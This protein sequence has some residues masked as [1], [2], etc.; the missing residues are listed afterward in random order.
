MQPEDN[1]GLVGDESSIKASFHLFQLQLET[2]PVLAMKTFVSTILY[3]FSHRALF[4]L[5]VLPSGENFHF[6]I[7]LFFLNSLT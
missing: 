6:T 3:I 7:P 2:K 1:C 4:S 5:K